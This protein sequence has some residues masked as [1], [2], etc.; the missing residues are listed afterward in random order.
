MKG[1]KM[2]E[3]RIR[4][5]FFSGFSPFFF[6]QSDPE[7]TNEPTNHP[8]YLLTTDE[9]GFQEVFL[10]LFFFERMLATREG[11]EESVI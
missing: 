8:T 1:E 3:S 2:G 5:F 4:F 11:G 7:Q 10:F 9:C 6:K